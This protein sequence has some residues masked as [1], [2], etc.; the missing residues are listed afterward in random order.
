M[1]Q[2]WTPEAIRSLGAVT[3]LPTLGSVFSLSAW[4]SY[5]MA[6]TGEWEE[7]GIS[8]IKTGRQY[9]VAVQ[10][11]LETL[12]LN[13]KSNPGTAPAEEGERN[14]SSEPQASPGKTADIIPDSS[15]SH[16]I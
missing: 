12:S 14:L 8:I 2:S 11:I 9:R 3:D 6:H 15:Q 1:N 16:M 10:S 5:Q 7:I 4:R 13:D